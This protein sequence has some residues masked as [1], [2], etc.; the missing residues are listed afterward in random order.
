MTTIPEICMVY[1][2]V[3]KTV[4]LEMAFT[5]LIGFAIGILAAWFNDR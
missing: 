2:E 5:M 1:T 4:R 3:F